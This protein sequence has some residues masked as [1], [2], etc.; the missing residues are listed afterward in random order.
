MMVGKDRKLMLLHFLSVYFT[1]FPTFL[2]LLKQKLYKI[3]I[4]GPVLKTH[5]IFTIFRKSYN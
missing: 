5:L 1:F 4:W 3:Y 2:I